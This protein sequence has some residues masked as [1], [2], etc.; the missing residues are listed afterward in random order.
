MI[1]THRTALL[2]TCDTFDTHV[3]C[4]TNNCKHFHRHK[5]YEIGNVSSILFH[6]LNYSYATKVLSSSKKTNLN[7]L[8]Y[9]YSECVDR[10][11]MYITPSKLFILILN[12]IIFKFDKSIALFRINCVTLVYSCYATC[13]TGRYTCIHA[14]VT[15]VS[16]GISL[17]LPEILLDC[18]SLKYCSIKIYVHEFR[19][20]IIRILNQTISM[21]TYELII[22]RRDNSTYYRYTLNVFHYL[23][24]YI[25]LRC[26]SNFMN[27]HKCL[28]QIIILP[29]PEQCVLLTYL[30]FTLYLLLIYLII[31]PHVLYT[32]W[33]CPSL[34][35]IVILNCHNSLAKSTKLLLFYTDIANTI[36]YMV[37]Y[38]S[39]HRLSIHNCNILHIPYNRLKNFIVSIVL[40]YHLSLLLHLHYYYMQ[41]CLFYH[42]LHLSFYSFSSFIIYTILSR[43]TIPPY[44]QLFLI[45]IYTYRGTY[46]YIIILYTLLIN[47]YC[48]NSIFHILWVTILKL[49]NMSLLAGVNRKF[50][51]IAIDLSLICY[52]FINIIVIMVN[53]IN[54]SSCYF[55]IFILSIYL[56]DSENDHAY[57]NLYNTAESFWIQF[58]N[59]LCNHSYNRK[60]ST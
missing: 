6:Y 43:I 36:L 10:H 60:L 24:N 1:N 2:T 22:Q 42:M 57:G 18:H 29:V 44:T 31:N 35:T 41:L 5:I 8:V 50:P 49:Y 11:I 46:V 20:H 19:G 34:S 28:E 32:D 47:L 51:F 58:Y 13:I 27:L 16:H 17:K 26:I 7:I 9:K 30:Y 59:I 52:L 56:Y 48:M 21:K 38:V 37:M 40:L 12:V 45:I 3:I 4:I 15:N 23:D 53:V 55:T 25:L 39:N 14:L 54:N 33:K